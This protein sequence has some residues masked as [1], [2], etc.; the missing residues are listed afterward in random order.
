MRPLVTC[1]IGVDETVY[2]TKN[3]DKKNGQTAMNSGKFYVYATPRN[4]L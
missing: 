3:F 4:V 2:E 1:S